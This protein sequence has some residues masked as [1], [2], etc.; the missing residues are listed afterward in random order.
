MNTIERSSDVISSTQMEDLGGIKSFPIYMGCVSH[1]KSDDLYVDMLWHI[2]PTTGLLQLKNLIPLDVLYS[3]PDNHSGAVGRIWM[4]HHQAFVDF[5]K[6][7]DPS[8]VL[9]IGGAHGILSKLYQQNSLDTDWTILEPN[10]IPVDGVKAN[11]IKGFFD[12]DFK[13]NDQVD[14]IVHSHVFEHIYEPNTFLKQIADCLDCGKH[15]IFS[16]PNMKE[17]LS[18][19]YTNCINF[20][21]S[22]FLTEPYIEYLLSRYGF[23]I[24]KREYFLEDH[25]IFYA[26]VRDTNLLPS[27]LPTGLYEENKKIYLDYVTYHENLILELN[28]K[29]AEID[30]KRKL[31]LFG[32]HVFA[33]YLVMFG[34]DVSRVE[35]L[36]DNDINKQGKRLYGTSLQV[37]SPRILAESEHPVVILKAGVYNEEIKQDILQNINQN[38]I[39]LE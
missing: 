17:M 31:Y 1:P 5:I 13:L 28:S 9:E 34:L 30:P 37:A 20:E 6:E 11:I 15:L 21:H 24:Q 10:P 36:L 25:S 32:A 23:R 7:F 39:F 8:S 16:L 27:E 2:S 22:V 26:C 14:A 4:K 29:I 35:C 33:Q 19:K 12:K 3:H 18:R 38:T